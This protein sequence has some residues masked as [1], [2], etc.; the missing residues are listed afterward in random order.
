M[1]ARLRHAAGHAGSARDVRG[2][3]AWHALVLRV[4]RDGGAFRLVAL[5]HVFGA[6][7]SSLLAT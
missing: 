7:C 2:G 6:R 5:V 3:G 1:G 4:V